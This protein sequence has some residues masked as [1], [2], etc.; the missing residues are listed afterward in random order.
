MP[1]NP[2]TNLLNVFQPGKPGF[3]DH[4]HYLAKCITGVII[5]YILYKKI[6][7]Y[8]FYWAII[9]VV[10]VLSPDN[11]TALAYDRIWAN[12]LGCG[13]G[14]CLYYI[15]LPDLL[16]L[17]IGVVLT[18]WV[19]IALNLV[20]TLRSALAALVIITIDIEQ[21]SKWYIALQRVFCVVAGCIVALV[22]T[23]AFD[24]IFKKMKKKAPPLPIEKQAS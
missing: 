14:I 21:G 6:P 18:I 7:Q 11:N 9:S 20:T 16:M 22:V 3:P 4:W 10:I 24:E 12:L 23:M 8:P 1:T 19:G 13:V 17:C 5:C 15:H 2:V